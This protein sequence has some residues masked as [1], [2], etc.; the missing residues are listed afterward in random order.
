MDAHATS[1]PSLGGAGISPSVPAER[2]D[3]LDDDENDD[4]E[5]EDGAAAGFDLASNE[6][7]G[8]GEQA[9]LGVDARLP[10]PDAKAADGALVDAR[11][12]KVADDFEGVVDPFGELRQL[13][14]APDDAPPELEPRV[15]QHVGE[16]APV[17]PFELT[18][19]ARQL[20]VEEIVVV[21]QLEKLRRGEFQNVRDVAAARRL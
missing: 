17:H 2:E 3:D 6:A 7:V 18:V 1:S 9:L 21:A 16:A 8:L 13:D 12:I 15:A 19:H 20:R 5:L 4:H 14:E 10:C 11:E